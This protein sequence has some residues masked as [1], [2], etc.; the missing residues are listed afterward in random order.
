MVLDCTFDTIPN[1]KRNLETIL[2]TANTSWKLD[3]RSHG[4]PFTDG[5]YIL[6][7]NE[8]LYPS[9]FVS[10]PG[11]VNLERKIVKR[12]GDHL[13]GE[14]SGRAEIEA[15]FWEY[16]SVR[17][18]Q[19]FQNQIPAANEFDAMVCVLWSRLGP[20]PHWPGREELFLG[21]EIR[22]R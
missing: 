8:R 4:K 9:S 10:S 1:E 17:Q 21:N 18:Q 3:C 19:T 20:P 2:T 14:Y 15:F 5:S 22:G 7:K 13:N 16:E 6:E 12:L 11:D